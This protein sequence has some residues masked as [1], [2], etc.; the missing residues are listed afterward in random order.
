MCLMLIPIWGNDQIIL[1][2]IFQMGWS[3]QLVTPLL[4]HPM[5]DKKVV[6]AF[7]QGRYLLLTE[8]I[9]FSED[10]TGVNMLFRVGYEKQP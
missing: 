10:W 9:D 4:H 3:H 2:H 7:S 1:I 6:A 8:L 5:F